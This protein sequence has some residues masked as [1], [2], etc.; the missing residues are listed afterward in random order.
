LFVSHAFRSE[1]AAI[2]RARPMIVSSSS[3]NAYTMS[4]V[5]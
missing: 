3:S 2:F 5:T 4:F 1:G